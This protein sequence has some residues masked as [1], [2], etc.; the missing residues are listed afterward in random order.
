MSKNFRMKKNCM[1]RKLMEI[2]Y[3]RGKKI[4]PG[5]GFCFVSMLQ[6]T[7]HKWREIARQRLIFFAY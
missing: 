6:S 4:R 7:H 5:N 1:D 3:F 2:I